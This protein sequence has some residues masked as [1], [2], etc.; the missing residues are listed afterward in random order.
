MYRDNLQI[1]STLFTHSLSQDSLV[2]ISQAIKIHS[3]QEFNT[4][5]YH[6]WQHIGLLLIKIETAKQLQQ[7]TFEESNNSTL[8]ILYKHKGLSLRQHQ[9]KVQN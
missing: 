2:Q 8:I 6:D 7:K 5:S 1:S 4:L 9:H 3:Q